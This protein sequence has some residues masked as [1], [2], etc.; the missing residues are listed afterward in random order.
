MRTLK[1]RLY[2]VQ[3]LVPEGSR[4]ADIGTDHGHLPISLIKTGVSKFVI[5]SDIKEKP[6]SVARANIE[7]CKI[8]NIETRLGDG[9]SSIKQGEVD[10]IVIAGMGGEVI[11]GILGNCSWIKDDRYTLVLQ[12]MTAADSLRRYLSSNG[13]ETLEEKAVEDTGRLYCVIK[14]VYCGRSL[15]QNETFYRIGKL[16]P[17]N[18]TDLLYIKKQL[19]IATKCKIDLEKSGRDFSEYANLCREINIILGEE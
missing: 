12:P 17:K 11:E 10:C 14:A 16:D 9:L 5:A 8:K 1:N 6:L 18:P 4:V 2:T 15:P 19:N 3:T 13:F 7:K